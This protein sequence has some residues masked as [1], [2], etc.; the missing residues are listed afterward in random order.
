MEDSVVTTYFVG[1]RRG[2]LL[3]VVRIGV[4][5]L[6]AIGLGVVGVED[7]QSVV[8]WCCWLWW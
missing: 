7:E 2:S 6:W 1:G 8:K 3:V 4:V 5:K